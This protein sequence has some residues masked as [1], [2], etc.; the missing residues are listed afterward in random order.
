MLSI[1]DSSCVR[2]LTIL[3]ACFI[4]FSLA[5]SMLGIHERFTNLGPLLYNFFGVGIVLAFSMYVFYL[6]VS[7]TSNSLKLEILG[8]FL[9]KFR[10]LTQ[11]EWK[12]IE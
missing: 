12:D 10:R 4:P 7:T 1:N 6:L 9:N 5:A 2:R 3:A 8:K 11:L